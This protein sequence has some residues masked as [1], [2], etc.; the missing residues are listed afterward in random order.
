M[1][2]DGGVRRAAAS[3]AT[4]AVLL[5]GTAL[6]CGGD[7]A[8]DG[9]SDPTA[10]CA[11]S[12]ADTCDATCSGACGSCGDGQ[13]C[14]SAGSCIAPAPAEMS[15]FVTSV[16]NGARGGDFG[17]ID[18]ADGFCQ[19]LAGAAGSARTFRAY[20]STSS[21]D[22]RD[23]IGAGPWTNFAGDVIAAD[24]EALH[25]EGLAAA[26]A[27]DETGQP[28]PNVSPDN[29]HDILTG[30]KLDGTASGA[31]CADYTSSSR[32]DVVTVGHCDAEDPVAEGASWNSAHDSNGC[33]PEE[34]RGTGSTARLYCF[35][36]D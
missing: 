12:C 33:D 7:D 31:S 30:S 2:P 36:I 20:L 1:R 17:G 18:G 24:V 28:V 16:G 5:A 9:P 21:E 27:L 22:A 25:A 13:I 8:A 10:E 6:G 15:F 29:E 23:R 14:S 4:A 34:L 35:A 3:A 19:S 32:D 26:H 11:E